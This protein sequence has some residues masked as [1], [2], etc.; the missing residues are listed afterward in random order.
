MRVIAGLA[1]VA[2]LVF[3]VFAVSI[4]RVDA[5]DHT[6]TIC[7]VQ[8][9]QSGQNDVEITVARVAWED[10]RGAHS[11]HVNDSVGTCAPAAPQTIRPADDPPA[12]DPPADDPPAD[13]PPADDPPADDPPADDPP[14]DDPPADDPP[15]DDPPADDPPADDPPADETTH[16]Q[17]T[18][19]QTT[20]P[21]IRPQ[22]IHPQTIH[23][24]TIHPQ[25]TLRAIRRRPGRREPG[26]WL[27]RPSNSRSTPPIEMVI[28][29]P[30]DPGES[31]PDETA[32][33]AAQP[34]DEAPPAPQI[35]GV[36]LAPSPASAGNCG[37]ACR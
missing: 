34:T 6:V 4:V 19:Q 28:D 17:T 3:G 32:P 1:A 9:G 22:T 18:H 36:Q 23:P 10:G 21:P 26:R 2:A 14:A 37:P 31:T 33:V 25:T 16:Q 20:R 5:S 7:H 15:A 8:A 11:N 12:D 35:L 24:Q 29:A 27:S 13:D 30:V